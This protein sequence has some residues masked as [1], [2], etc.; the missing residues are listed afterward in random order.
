MP[1]LKT[2]DRIAL[3]AMLVTALSIPLAGHAAPDARNR[4]SHAVLQDDTF[5]AI[6]PGM[7]VDE[8]VALIGQPA[9]KE[10]FERSHATAWDYPYRDSWG[11][12][13][14]FSLMV[15]DDGRVVSKISVRKDAG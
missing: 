3:A 15:G 12:E 10:R 9:R 8:V 6:V 7:G 2:V 4:A 13:A 1:Q 5:Q 14:V 11:Y